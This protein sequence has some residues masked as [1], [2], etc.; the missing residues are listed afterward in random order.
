VSIV[1]RNVTTTYVVCGA[2]IHVT[3][4][5]DPPAISIAAAKAGSPLQIALQSEAELATA[6][7]RRGATLREV[8]A[9]L[10]QPEC[11]DFRSRAW[12]AVA[13]NELD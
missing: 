4:D 3:I 5:D 8:L 13:E 10:R 9:L 12:N 11:D 1:T 6:L 2:K 7:L